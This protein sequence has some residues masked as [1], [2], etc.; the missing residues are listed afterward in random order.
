MTQVKLRQQGVTLPETNEYTSML[1]LTVEGH[2]G[3]APHG[4]DIV[5]AAESI[6]VQAMAGALDRLDEKLL[7]DFA[8]DGTPGSG[9]VGITAVPTTRGWERVRGVF[10]NTMMGFSLLARNYPKYVS[11]AYESTEKEDLYEG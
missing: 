9:C 3:F 10:E 6:L 7:Y 8:V 1:C 5:C 2:A 11:V 4:K